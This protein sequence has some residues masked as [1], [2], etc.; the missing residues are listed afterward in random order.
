MRWRIIYCCPP[1]YLQH[2]YA[3]RSRRRH[4]VRRWQSFAVMRVM[5][6]AKNWRHSLRVSCR[7]TGFAV[8][9]LADS[10][11]AIQPLIVGDNSRALQLAEKLRQQNC[12][13]TAIRPPTVPAGTARLRLTLT[14]AHEMQDIDRLLEGAAWQRVM[15][16][17]HCSGIW[18]GNRAYEQHADLQRQVLTSYWQCFHS[19]NTCTGRGLWTGWMSRHWRERHAQVT[20]LNLSPP[21]L[22]QA[23]E[24]CRRPLLSGGRYRILPLATAT[25]DLAWVISRYGG[26]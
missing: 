5:H 7:S 9:T 14:A 18:S 16:A 26:A 13:V 11:S 10:C 3:A 6:G 12:W 23:P 4:Y 24:G 15:P 20:A 25:F 21:M 8:Y 1:S 17:S 2:Q 22:V 19:V